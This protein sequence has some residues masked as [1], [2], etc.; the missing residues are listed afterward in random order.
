MAASEWGVGWGVGVSHMLH[1]KVTARIIV[2]SCQVGRNVSAPR[3]PPLLA[4]SK[5]SVQGECERFLPIWS[6]PFMSV[7][8]GV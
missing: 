4:G 5:G 2:P 1:R 6:F 3:L 8:E 7:H